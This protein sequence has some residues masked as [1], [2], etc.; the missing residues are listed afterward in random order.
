[1]KADPEM[2]HDTAADQQPR[3]KV[4]IG[5][6]LF[7]V[8]LARSSGEE[9]ERDTESPPPPEE[10]RKRLKTD[11]SDLL[12]RPLSEILGDEAPKRSSRKSKQSAKAK[13]AAEAA[14]VFEKVARKVGRTR[15]Y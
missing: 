2:D 1:M 3:R 12:T 6:E 9:G 13:E 14:E 7:I 5:E 11:D 15:N 8:H 4:S 10:P